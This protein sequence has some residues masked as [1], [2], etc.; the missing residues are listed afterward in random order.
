MACG[1]SG[2]GVP[3]V[4]LVMVHPESGRIEIVQAENF[5]NR[6]FSVTTQVPSGFLSSR[7]P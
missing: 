1:I 3:T 7:A 6:L 5:R 4:Q 2:R